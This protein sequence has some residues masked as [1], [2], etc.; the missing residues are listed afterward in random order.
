[1][2]HKAGRLA[3]V[4]A[5]RVC[6]ESIAMRCAKVTAA[7][8]S[9]HV[10]RSHAALHA[11]WRKLCYVKFYDGGELMSA[12]HSDCAPIATTESLRRIRKLR[13]RVRR[14][15]ALRWQTMQAPAMPKKQQLKTFLN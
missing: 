2:E 1:M 12:R 13:V 10:K 3:N 14:D 7:A 5:P 9:S 8:T 11:S 6:E 15:V 4:V